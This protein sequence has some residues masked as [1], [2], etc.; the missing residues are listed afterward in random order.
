MQMEDFSHA[1]DAQEW[2][3]K[4]RAKLIAQIHAESKSFL[5]SVQNAAWRN[6]HQ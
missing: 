3:G 2:C 6:L 4:V 5:F 1:V